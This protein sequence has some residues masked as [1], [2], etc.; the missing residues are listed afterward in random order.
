VKKLA[1]VIAMSGV[2]L[3]GCDVGPADGAGGTIA[4]SDASTNGSQQSSGSG[5]TDDGGTSSGGATQESDATAL[6]TRG[7]PAPIGATASIGDW[8]VTITNV[9]RDAT[10]RVLEANMFNDEPVEGRSF[11]LWEVEAIYTGTESATAWIDL[12]W[13]I[14]GAAGNSFGSGM[15]DYCGV[16]PNSIND[17]GETFPGA[18]VTGNVCIAAESAQVDGGTILVEELFG[19]SRT[20]FAIP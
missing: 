14:V 2:V 8:D 7:N 4:G 18:V 6:G 12:N 17:K 10:A 1:I 15:D 3:A 9:D 20:F 19:G 5:A 13:K 11:V 16:I